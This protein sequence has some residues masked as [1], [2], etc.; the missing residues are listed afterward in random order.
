MGARK[1]APGK[2]VRG[3]RKT[4]AACA[5]ACVARALHAASRSQLAGSF[6]ARSTKPSHT[7]GRCRPKR[8]WYCGMRPFF[9]RSSPVPSTSDGLVGPYP[10]CHIAFCI[11]PRRGGRAGRHIITEAKRRSAAQR[12]D[13]TKQ[14][15]LQMI[16]T[17]ANKRGGNTGAGR[18]QRTVTLPSPPPPTFKASSAARHPF[19]PTASIIPRLKTT[20]EPP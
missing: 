8:H 9:C 11:M 1:K 5:V 17:A 15:R 19:S 20:P 10:A 3:G 18:L 16:S 7:N 14:A 12:R 2:L 13:R 6:S 4:R